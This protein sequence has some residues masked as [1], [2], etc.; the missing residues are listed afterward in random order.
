MSSLDRRDTM[1]ATFDRRRTMP[2]LPP[3][4]KPD[5]PRQ[6]PTAARSA[7]PLGGLRLAL[8]IRLLEI[9]PGPARIAKFLQSRRQNLPA[10]REHP[11]RPEAHNEFARRGARH[12]G[13]AKAER[14]VV[15]NTRTGICAL[16]PRPVWPSRRQRS[17]FHARHQG[18]LQTTSASP[19]RSRRYYEPSSRALRSSKVMS[20]ALGINRR[21]PFAG[22]VSRVPVLKGLPDRG[23]IPCLRKTTTGRRAEEW[24]RKIVSIKE[25]CSSNAGNYQTT[26][27]AHMAAN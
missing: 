9:H 19:M 6:R 23:Q 3:V 10:Q 24:T 27:C 25:S 2:A 26:P 4:E 15:P 13:L 11:R 18:V 22:C 12:P 5:C 1:V 17:R 8:K 20:L 7:G 16:A 14:F 21:R